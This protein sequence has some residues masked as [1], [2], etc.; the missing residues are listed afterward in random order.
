MGDGFLITV[1]FKDFKAIVRFRIVACGYHDA[2]MNSFDTHAKG[3]YF[4]RA[5][6][7][8]KGF[9]TRSQKTGDQRVG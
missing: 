8:V 4:R 3:H 7:E 9:T 6:P 5:K 2:Q 1:G